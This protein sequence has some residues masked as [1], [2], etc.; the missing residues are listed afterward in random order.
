METF[1]RLSDFVL[2]K[3]VANYS[4][5]MGGSVRVRGSCF[6]R[7]KAYQ[8]VRVGEMSALDAACKSSELLNLRFCWIFP[9]VSSDAFAFPPPPLS[10][11][12]GANGSNH[13]AVKKFA[14]KTRTAEGKG[15]CFQRNNGKCNGKIAGLCQICESPEHGKKQCPMRLAL[16]DAGAPAKE[17]SR[18]RDRDPLVSLQPSLRS[19]AVGAKSTVLFATPRPN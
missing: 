9:T 14:L 3:H 17:G 16:L 12:K 13:R 15:I 18:R 2:G 10:R 19:P 5:M 6:F 11:G 8:L 1:R 4:L 7:K